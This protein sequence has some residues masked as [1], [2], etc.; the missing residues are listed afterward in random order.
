M[1]TFG[2][3]CSDEAR[4]LF[5]YRYQVDRP[6]NFHL[7]IDRVANTGTFDEIRLETGSQLPG[8]RLVLRPVGDQPPTS[9][10]T[11]VLPIEPYNRIA[12]QINKLDVSKVLF[13]HG[14]RGDED[15]SHWF[16]MRWSTVST[17][18][19]A[20]TGDRGKAAWAV[21]SSCNTESARGPD[22]V[23]C[24]PYRAHLEVAGETRG[25][26]G[27]DDRRRDGADPDT[28]RSQKVGKGC[29]DRK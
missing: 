21:R 24:T 2:S 6:P 1:Q 22:G 28:G 11:D 29:T 27:D 9:I 4:S 3:R 12:F 20:G 13:V 26:A 7:V 5:T 17:I 25:Q 10:D 19:S 16:S 8:V 23:Y 14:Q 15:D 18:F